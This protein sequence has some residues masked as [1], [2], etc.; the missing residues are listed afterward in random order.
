[1]NWTLEQQLQNY[2]THSRLFAQVDSLLTSLATV[3][4]LYV[5]VTGA[6]WIVLIPNTFHLPASIVALA[7]G[8]HGV[9]SLAV[10]F[11]LLGMA[12]TLNQRFDFAVA[13]GDTYWPRIEALG[14]AAYRTSHRGWIRKIS[15]RKQSWFWPLV[16]LIGGLASVILAVFVLC[17]SPAK[18]RA[19]EDRFALLKQA[20][21]PYQVTRAQYLIDKAG[22]DTGKSSVQ[23]LLKK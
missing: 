13:M 8:L 3:A 11:A 12:L 6:T 7:L 15:L 22:C 1:M 5:A 10:L 18:N 19:C 4:N 9:L 17:E 2:E 21:E 20:T 14:K 16:P 23:D